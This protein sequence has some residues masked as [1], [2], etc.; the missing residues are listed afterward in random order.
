MA[1][2]ITLL[3]GSV[4]LFA[5]GTKPISRGLKPRIPLLSDVRA[6]ARTYLRCKNKDD[7]SARTRT[8][9][10]QEQG[11]CKCKNKDD[12]GSFRKLFKQILIGGDLWTEDEGDDAAECTGV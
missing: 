5:G 7:A 2:L 10:V 9:Q 12:A 8:M 4:A 1:C 3:E 11:R 6:E